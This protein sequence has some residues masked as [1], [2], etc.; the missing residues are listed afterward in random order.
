MREVSVKL[1]SGS[2][3]INRVTRP[4]RVDATNDKLGDEKEVVGGSFA[5]Q[6]C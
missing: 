5:E 2:S 1:N 4:R 3:W 6:N